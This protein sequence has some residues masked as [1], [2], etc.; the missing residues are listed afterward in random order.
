MQDDNK[1]YLP[2]CHC[3]F[4]HIALHIVYIFIVLVNSI[5]KPLLDIKYVR[6][7]RTT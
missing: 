5:L 7:L 6:G 2:G 3:G 1:D 4:L